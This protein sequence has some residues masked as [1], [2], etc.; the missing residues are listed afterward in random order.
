MYHWRVGLAYCIQS[1]TFTLSLKTGF[2]IYIFQQL[3]L[4]LGFCV[5]ENGKYGLFSKKYCLIE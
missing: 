1:N 3:T 5:P 4:I 2:V